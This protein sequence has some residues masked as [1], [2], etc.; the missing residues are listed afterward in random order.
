LQA[1]A[2]VPVPVAGQGEGAGS[3]PSEAPREEREEVEK[4][5][6]D[7]KLITLCERLNTVETSLE[8]LRKEEE[9]ERAMVLLPVSRSVYVP[10]GIW[11][12]RSDLHKQHP[13]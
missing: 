6:V 2:R 4:K 7:L 10:G 12:T 13:K 5:V 11:N 9:D 8:R 1:Q 3:V